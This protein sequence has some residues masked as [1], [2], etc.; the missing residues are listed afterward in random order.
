MLAIAFIAGL[1]LFLLVWLNSRKHYDFYKA[2]GSEAV[3][4]TS[5]ALPAPLPPDLAGN[6]ASGLSLRKDA[7]IAPSSPPPVAAPPSPPPPAST[8]TPPPPASTDPIPVHT[9]APR[10]PQEPLRRGVGGTVRV[11]VSVAMDGSVADQAIA[12]SSGNRE[13]DRAALDA[14]RRWQFKPATRAGQPIASEA[15][16]P[17]VFKPGQ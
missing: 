6:T 13:L 5:D 1:L 3:S 2:D 16:V 15:L 11:R 17:I 7:P 12:E 4:G 14:V 10:Y 9:A 8:A